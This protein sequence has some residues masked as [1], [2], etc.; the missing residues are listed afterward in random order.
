MTRASVIAA[1]FVAAV[2]LEQIREASAAAVYDASE[3]T[4]LIAA[5]LTR[6]ALIVAL[7]GRTKARLDL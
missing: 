6:L 3:R 1:L 4:F 7:A 5:G 2:G